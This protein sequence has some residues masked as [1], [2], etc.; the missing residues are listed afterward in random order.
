MLKRGVQ[1]TKDLER[2]AQL[3][4][5]ALDFDAVPDQFIDEL[6]DFLR[7]PTGAMRLRPIQALALSEM[8]DFG[9]LFGSIRV[10]GGKTLLSALAPTVLEASSALLLVPA[11]LRDKTRRELTELRKHW[12]I[13][14]NLTVESYEMLGRVQGS[15]LIER[16]K[17][18]LIVADEAHKLK[19][20]KA[21]CTKRVRRYI[22]ENPNTK[23]V[24]LSGTITK[25]SILDYHHVIYWCFPKHAPQPKH[26]PDVLEWSLALDEKVEDFARLSPGALSVFYNDEERQIAEHTPTQAAR[27]AY[28]RRLSE[29]PG[30][31]ATSDKYAGSSLTLEVVTPKVSK[32]VEEALA[33][34]RVD[35]E[36]PD[37]HPVSDFVALWRHARELV[38]GFY[39]VW[40]PRPPEHWLEARRNMS[41]FVR[42]IL[43]H[44]R[45]G[46][47]S[48]LQVF[49]R[50]PDEPV[51]ATWQAVRNDFVPNV[52]AKWV[53]DTLLAYAE[54]WMKRNAG[55]VWVEHRAF[56]EKLAA[57]TGADYYADGGKNKR[58]QAIALHDPSKPLIA[59]VASNA[60]GQNLQAWSQNLVVSCAPTGILWEQLLGRTHRDGQQAEEVTCQI[61][62]ACEEQRRGLQQARAD[63]RYLQD[64]LRQEQKLM[65]ADWVLPANFTL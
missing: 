8:H 58:G 32:P 26:F 46:I 1:R 5:R 55:I 52:E 64:T 10:G 48:P 16:V 50:Y 37:G 53:D 14:D 57:L 56:G 31:I 24:A 33:R 20:T 6:T 61:I 40:N 27:L 51:I 4:R 38:C 7:T 35:W 63:A 3:P 12:Q 60:E 29:T 2:I 30:I 39:Y 11:K 22:R 17:P 44:N 43:K 54:D 13:A 15:N 34:L 36:T 9:G 19:N 47:D 23:F 42:E 21:A 25:R 41:Q 45:S 65:H 18:D 59:S 49:Q 28:G 62:I